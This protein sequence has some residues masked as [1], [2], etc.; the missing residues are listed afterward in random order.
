V[1]TTFSDGEGADRRP[2]A[3]GDQPVVAALPILYPPERYLLAGL[4]CRLCQ[5]V[6]RG[7]SGF[8]NDHASAVQDLDRTDLG[9]GG[10]ESAI[11]RSGRLALQLS[12]DLLSA[13]ARR[14]PC[15]LPERPIEDEDHG[16]AGED[17]A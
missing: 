3:A 10:E 7:S 12:G 11:E 2:R 13:R 9:I 5:W 6:L 15:R 4:D 14:V 1:V 8:R 16:S 17:E